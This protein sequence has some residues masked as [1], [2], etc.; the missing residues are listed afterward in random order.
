MEN[1]SSTWLTGKGKNILTG[2]D[3]KI[4]ASSFTII[5]PRQYRSPGGSNQGP[6]QS[7]NAPATCGCCSRTGFNLSVAEGFFLFTDNIADMAKEFTLAGEDLVK[8]V[9]ENEQTFSHFRDISWDE[10]EI[11]LHFTVDIAVNNTTEVVERSINP[12]GTDFKKE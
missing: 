3:T 8:A 12:N 6:I 9:A 2:R 5:N 7:Y 4:T 10:E 1:L 11:H